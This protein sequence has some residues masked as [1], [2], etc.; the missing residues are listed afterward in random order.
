MTITPFKHNKTI[1]FLFFW[2]G[3]GFLAF[4]CRASN[5]RT[6]E[7]KIVGVCSCRI[8]TN[9]V[10]TGGKEGNQELQWKLQQ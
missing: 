3:G 2:L 1:D 9:M 8:T 6:D 10:P 7:T 4:V 5:E